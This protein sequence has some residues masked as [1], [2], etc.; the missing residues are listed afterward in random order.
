MY[1]LPPNQGCALF[2]MSYSASFNTF[3]KMTACLDFHKQRQQ[4]RAQCIMK[5]SCFK[6]ATE[7]N[8]SLGIHTQTVLLQFQMPYTIRRPQY[9]YHFFFCSGTRGDLG[10]VIIR[11]RSEDNNVVSWVINPCFL[12]AHG[13]R[14]DLTKRKKLS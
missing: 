11:S 14:F 7:H 6:Y 2:F 4:L 13:D 8:L 1:G 9:L 12:L 3:S 10:K 5:V